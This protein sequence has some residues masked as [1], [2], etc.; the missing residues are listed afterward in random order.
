M[1]QA[2]PIDLST[3]NGF[4][5]MDLR[6]EV[7]D[8]GLFFANTGLVVDIYNPDYFATMTPCGGVTETIPYRDCFQPIYGNGCDDTSSLIY[9]APVA[10]WTRQFEDR[11]ADAPGAIGARSVVWGFHAVYFNP[12]QV[13]DAIGV[14]VHDEWQLERN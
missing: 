7:S 12:D 11:I 8:P 10:F 5:Q 2:V 13:R 4:P 6:P 1:R 14:I 3:G 9:N